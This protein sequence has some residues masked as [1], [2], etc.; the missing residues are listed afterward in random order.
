VGDAF[1]KLHA[2]G[3]TLCFGETTELTGGEHLV[4]ARCKTPEI[5]EQFMAMFDR[6]QRVIEAKDAVS[7]LTFACEH[8][9]STSF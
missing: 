8:I 1:D 7:S 2:L 3:S 4:A 9:S 5:R 6:Y